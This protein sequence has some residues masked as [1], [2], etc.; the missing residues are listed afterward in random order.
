VAVLVAHEHHGHA[1]RQQQ[2]GGQVALLARAQAQHGRRPRRA[3]RAAVPGQVVLLAVPAR[4]AAARRARGVPALACMRSCTC[5]AMTHVSW[6]RDQLTVLALPRAQHARRVH[7]LPHFQ[8]L[9][10][11]LLAV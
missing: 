9:R 5:H 4:A 7:A 3:L 6:G 2:R 10:P 11:S 1:L 8:T